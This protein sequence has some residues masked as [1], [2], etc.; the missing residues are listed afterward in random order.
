MDNT[1]DQPLTPRPGSKVTTPPDHW[2]GSKVTTP[3]PWARVKGHN[4]S[5]QARVKDHNI[6]PPGQAGSS[7][8]TGMHSCIGYAS[9]NMLALPYLN[10]NMV[11]STLHFTNS[12][13]ILASFV[14][15]IMAGGFLFPLTLSN[16]SRRPSLGI[17]Y[18]VTVYDI[19]RA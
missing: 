8:P 9:T 15:A 19:K 11:V 17:S 7:H 13:E 14:V 16:R 1:K 5:P 6:P 3:P 2:P 4:T 18:E 12:L 10:T